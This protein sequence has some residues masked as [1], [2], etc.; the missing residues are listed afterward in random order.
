MAK[1]V[2]FMLGI[3]TTVKNWKIY[4]F[5]IENLNAER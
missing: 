1:M 4:A 5:D 2:N 3:F